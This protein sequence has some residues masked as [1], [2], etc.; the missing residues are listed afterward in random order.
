MFCLFWWEFT[1]LGLTRPSVFCHK[2]SALCL[3][4]PQVIIFPLVMS[5]FCWSWCCVLPV[6]WPVSLALL[7]ELELTFTHGQWLCC[8]SH[9][10]THMDA[11]PPLTALLRLTTSSHTLNTSF[12]AFLLYIA[13]QMFFLQ[14]SIWTG[15]IHTKVLNKWSPWG[16]LLIA[17]ANYIQFTSL[18]LSTAPRLDCG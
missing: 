3:S 2:W 14:R 9:P 15:L 8:V 11:Q 6:S 12:P 5:L 4:P 1:A 18:F 7:C 17:T 10:N 13:S 16:S